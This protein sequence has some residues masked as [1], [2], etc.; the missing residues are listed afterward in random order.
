MLHDCYIEC[1]DMPHINHFNNTHTLVSIFMF[2]GVCDRI[3]PQID[4]I[5]LFFQ[6]VLVFNF[7]A[8]IYVGE[9]DIEFSK[10]IQLKTNYT[11]LDSQNYIMKIRTHFIQIAILYVNLKRNCSR[12]F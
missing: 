2:I 3:N 7:T 8:Y 1:D 6:H 11:Y 10:T 9:I 5:G 12:F 4:I